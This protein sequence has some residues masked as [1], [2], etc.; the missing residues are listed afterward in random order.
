[1]KK[2]FIEPEILVCKFSAED[3]I[4]ESAAAT[5]VDAV[6]SE[7]NKTVSAAYTAEWDIMQ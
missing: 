2:N 6:K 7:L 4:T 3:I 5:A 1:M